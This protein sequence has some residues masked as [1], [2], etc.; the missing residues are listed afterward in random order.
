MNC[1]QHHIATPLYDESDF[2]V[3]HR[4]RCQIKDTKIP[5]PIS[6]GLLDL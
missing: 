2:C 5:L 4:Y 1:S 3:E 6:L